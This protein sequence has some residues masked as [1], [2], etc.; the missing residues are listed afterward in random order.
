MFGLYNNIIFPPKYN[1]H[2]SYGSVSTVTI[3]H[4]K[5][6]IQ[7]LPQRKMK[8]LSN[9]PIMP[10]IMLRLKKWFGSKIGDIITLSYLNIL[11]NLK[12]IKLRFNSANSKNVLYSK[13]I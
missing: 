5:V 12:L 1:F 11:I 10:L 13:T 2:F 4:K 3:Y 6:N 8:Y 7:D 9:V